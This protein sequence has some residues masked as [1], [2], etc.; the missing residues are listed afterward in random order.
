[1]TDKSTKKTKSAPL[2]SDMI[3]G[4]MWMIAM[5]WAIRSIGLVSTAILA[6]L[7]TPAD[8]GLIAMAMLFIG[9]LEVFSSFG[10]DLALIRDHKANR[11]HYDTAWTFK[12]IQGVALAVIMV[13]AAPYLALYFH[14]TKV[15]NV[16]RVLAVATLVSG[17]QNIGIVA[18]RKELDFASEFKYMV[19]VKLISFIVTIIFAFYF[20]NYWALVLGVLASKFANVILSFVMHPFRPKVSL[21]KAGVLWHFSKWMVVL[22]FGVFIT[23]KIDE[24]LIGGMK[25]TVDLGFYN[26]GSDLTSMTSNEIGRASCRERV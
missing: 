8:F 10:V 2:R 13:F 6:R 17:F 21:K 22:D 18:F 15:V 9:L 1:M 16:I 11:E 14:E 7:L 23:G 19:Y 25:S 26:V 12:L 5:R 3:K 20:K 24:I 4:S